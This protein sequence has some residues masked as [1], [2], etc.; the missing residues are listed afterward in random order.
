VANLFIIDGSNNHFIIPLARPTNISPAQILSN[1][2]TIALAL[3]YYANANFQWCQGTILA[4]PTSGNS[5]LLASRDS[6]AHLISNHCAC[7]NVQAQNLEEI[8]D[9]AIYVNNL[10]A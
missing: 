2:Q 4:Y 7:T 3:L 6:T 9:T 5:L 10:Y 8:K 1:D